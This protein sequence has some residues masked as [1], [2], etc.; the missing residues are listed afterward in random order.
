M[1]IIFDGREYATDIENRIRLKL[2]KPGRKPKLVTIC[3]PQDPGGRIYSKI[4]AAKAAELGVKFVQYDIHSTT[5]PEGLVVNLN[6][7]KSVNGLLIQLPLMDDPARDA[8]LC[9]LITPAKD[10]DGLNARSGVVPATVRAVT[11]ILKDALQETNPKPEYPVKI[12]VVGSDG[13]VG[14]ALTR[15]LK[16]N[17]RFEIYYLDKYSFS[18]DKLVGADAVISVTGQEGLIRPEFVREGVVAIDVGFPH[19]D[20]RPEVAEKCAFFTPVPGGVGP[21]TVAMLFMNLV[22][23]YYGSN[24]K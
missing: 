11:E 24:R 23:L 6:K 7:D 12:A 14:R 13:T 3:N 18:I 4:K 20:F 10:V 21:V 5:D 22:D 2:T 16:K 8:K 9:Q 17:S 19:G 15:Q 1:A